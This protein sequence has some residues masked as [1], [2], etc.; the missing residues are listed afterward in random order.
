MN[1]H[2]D[3]IESTPFEAPDLDQTPQRRR[4]SKVAIF[5]SGAGIALAA[6]GWF[7]FTATAVKFVT[8]PDEATLAVTDGFSY[9]LGDQWLIRPGEI[10]VAAIAE[11]YRPLSQRVEILS[12][13]SQQVELVLDPLPGLLSISANA[14]GA[15]VSVDG[16]VIGDTPINDA[17]IEAGIRSV[18]LT[19]P[20]FKDLSTEVEITGR[21]VKQALE[22]ELLPAWADIT[23]SSMPE[24]ATII[25]D[26]A[27]AGQTPTTLEL[28]EGQRSIQLSLA[29]F[30]PAN[31]MIEVVSSIPQVLPPFAL[32]PADAQVMITTTPPGASIQLDGQYRGQSPINLAVTPQQRLAITANKAGYEPSEATLFLAPNEEKQ[33]SMSLSPQQGRLA[34]ST[35]PA[36]AEIL[37]DGKPAPDLRQGMDLVSRPYVITIK[38]TG[39]AE[40]TER[41]TPIVGQLQT[42]NFELLSLE[43]ARLA[44]IPARLLTGQGSPLQL[45]KP[46]T[47]Q[48]GAPRRARG[49]RSNE[50]EREVA[51]SQ[52]FYIGRFEVTNREYLEF[53]P[54]HEPGLLGRILLNER[55]RP[56]VNLSWSR[57]VEF[58]NW[59]SRRDALTPAYTQVDG[60]WQLTQPF[61]DGYRLPTESEWVLALAAVNQAND[62][63]TFPWGESL[64][65]AEQ[66]ANIADESATGAVPYIVQGYDDGF[67]G[68]APV[69]RF[70]ANSLGLHD[71]TGNAAEWVN[72][73]YS[74]APSKSVETDRIGPV[75]GDVFVIRG[76]SFLMGR[77]GELRTAFRDFGQEGRQDVGFRL[78]RSIPTDARGQ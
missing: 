74:V 56:V 16:E 62:K 42:L 23:L 24:G 32:E 46:G 47:V 44:R 66:V 11:G 30:K 25:V 51:I 37:M 21:N 59:L 68:P 15:L 78:A 3:R 26:D 38:K 65:P 64:T 63:P 8:N 69:G 41:V 27:E 6:I 39:Y 55:D 28:L 71:L 1:D 49:R 60:E 61:T 33:L 31:T 13:T 75:S 58:C 7:L 50:I 40:V 72:D 36:D 48:L 12:A 14:I 70:P 54:S 29:G 57:A 5:L 52:P 45:V 67:R 22:L 18:Q 53:D 19:H 17:L 4:L 9:R 20:R 73:R 10:A 43:A 77:F 2:R 76:S 35:L 34:V